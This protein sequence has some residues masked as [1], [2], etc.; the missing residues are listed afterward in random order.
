MGGCI[1]ADVRAGYVYDSNVSSFWELSD[2]ASTIQQKS[3][4]LDQF[5][6][7]IESRSKLGGFAEYDA[8]FLKTPA[9][10][11]SQNLIA[12]KSLQGRMHQI[13]D[14]DPNSLQYQ[15]AIAQITAQ[16]QGEAKNMLDVFEGAWYLQNHFWL[17]DWV[18]A[19]QGIVVAIF[20]IIFGI[21]AFS[22][23]LE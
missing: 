21:G 16:E 13:I 12:L 6:G 3:E 10:S 8:M 20:C 15:Q 11:F 19:I 22:D 23:V 2:R 1:A 7:A 17:W 4:Y 18:E 9:N 5:V 14:M